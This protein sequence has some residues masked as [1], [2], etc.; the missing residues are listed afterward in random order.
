MRLH[1]VWGGC[2]QR[3]LVLGEE[4]GTVLMGRH[5]VRLGGKRGKQGLNG[6]QRERETVRASPV[7]P[8]GGLLQ[9]DSY[10][11]VRRG[12][13][14]CADAWGRL[15]KYLLRLIVNAQHLRAYAS[16]QRKATVLYVGGAD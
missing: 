7:P 8:F 9:V 14:R 4:M 6:S 1:P 10:V 3:F 5:M 16:G 11:F 12:G 15:P 2:L 13:G